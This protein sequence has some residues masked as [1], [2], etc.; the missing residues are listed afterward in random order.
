MSSVPSF[1]YHQPRF[2]S[3]VQ[4]GPYRLTT[5]PAH[6]FPRQ[7]SRPLL[8]QLISSLWQQVTGTGR[9]LHAPQRQNDLLLGWPSVVDDQPLAWLAGGFV[10]ANHQPLPKINEL[11]PTL[12]FY[13]WQVLITTG[14]RHTPA[15][16]FLNKQFANQWYVVALHRVNNTTLDITI[17]ATAG[18]P[19]GYHDPQTNPLA[20]GHL[21][22]K[23]QLILALHS[24]ADDH[25][26]WRGFLLG[27]DWSHVRKDDLLSIAA[28]NSTLEQQNNLRLAFN[29]ALWSHYHRRT[30]PAPRAWVLA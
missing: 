20:R 11:R 28:A 16:E 4:H 25:P 27:R 15:I 30:V 22:T 14:Q 29:R 7:L 12:Q 6:P 23:E 9:V 3:F 18:N 17:D 1:D 24:Y 5:D 8:G 21:L 19:A 2:E 10:W 26:A 13:D